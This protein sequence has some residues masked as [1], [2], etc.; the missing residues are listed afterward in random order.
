MNEKSFIRISMTLSIVGIVVLF[1]ILQ[2][3]EITQTDEITENIGNTV[4][5]R[6]KVM[7]LK[8]YEKVSYLTIARIVPTE[9]IL[10][11]EKNISL[12]VGLPVEIEVEITED[13]NDI[14]LIGQKI[15]LN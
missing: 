1:F 5:V 13:K 11:K 8:D 3:I 7:E 9:V 6:G 15:T 2:S 4:K 12:S 14:I 10:F